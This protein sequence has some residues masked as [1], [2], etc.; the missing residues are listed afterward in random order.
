MRK[1]M[2]RSRERESE[3]HYANSDE[4]NVTAAKCVLRINRKAII[5]I[6]NSKVAISIMTK[7]LMKKLDYE[8]N[9]PFRIVV[10][11]A[12]GDRIRSLEI[13]NGITISFEKI[14]E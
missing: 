5:A 10:V 7:P 12:N 8:P 1:A 9:R 6:V 11:T 14:L 13:I 3:T 4:E 2:Q